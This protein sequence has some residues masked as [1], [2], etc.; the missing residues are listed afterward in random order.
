MNRFG[1]RLVFLL[2]LVL[3]FSVFV[4]DAQTKKKKKTTAVPAATTTTTP[5]VEPLVIS[6]AEDFPD[7]GS[8]KPVATPTPSVDSSNAYITDLE[9]RIRSLESSSNKKDPDA[10]QKRLLLNLDILTR[11]EQRSE[12]L[13]KQSYD[14][15]EKE[16]D[17][18][19][20]MDRIEYELRPESID[21]TVAFAGTLRPEELRA[22]RRKSLE[23]EKANLQSLLTEIQRTRSNLEVTLERSDA[24]VEKLRTKLE[25][26]IDTA[27][28]DDP[29]DQ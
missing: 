24:L 16:S 6:R 8:V 26:E 2:S 19:A 10:K 4:V 29:K 28:D 23:S 13:R 9:N 5:P 12:T 18:H 3:V 27:L 22:N 21:K 14:L 20:K 7:E 1:S 11:A 17:I 25:K 15:L